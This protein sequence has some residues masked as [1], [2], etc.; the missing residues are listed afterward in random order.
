M[1][2]LM[3]CF[4]SVFFLMIRR[5]PSSTRTDTRFPYTTLFRSWP[6][7]AGCCA[8]RPTTCAAT[9]RRKPPKTSPGTNAS[10]CPAA[11]GAATPG[12]CAIR[13]EE[14]T[15]ELQSLMRISYAVFCLKKKIYR[16]QKTH[17]NT[18]K[19]RQNITNKHVAYN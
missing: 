17:N 8:P 7:T 1:Y 6:A 3:F 13:S 5:P 9:A 2:F 15:S 11:R 10:C 19:K 16:Q 4:V 14:H 18:Q 12:G